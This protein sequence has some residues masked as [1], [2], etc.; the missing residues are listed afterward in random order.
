MSTRTILILQG[1]T[2]FISFV[3]LGAAIAIPEF[4]GKDFVVLVI[5]GLAAAFSVVMQHLGNQTPPPEV[6]K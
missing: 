4:P 5:G 6:P 3:N 2:A 1:V